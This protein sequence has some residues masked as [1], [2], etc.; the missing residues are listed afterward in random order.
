[1][2]NHDPPPTEGPNKQQPTSH[3]YD[4]KWNYPVVAVSWYDAVTY[5]NWLSKV[6]GFEP[7][8]NTTTWNYD[9]SKNGFHLP[10]EAQWEKAARGNLEQMDF[11]WGN[12]PPD[13]G[14]CNYL[15]YNGSLI[16]IMANLDGNGKGTLPVDTLT[17]NGY[18]LFNM[19]G[20]VWEWCNDWYQDDYYSQSPSP[21]KNP[22]G[23][24]VG[25]KKVIRGGAWNSS[26]IYL[27]CYYR[28][29]KV[30]HT[31]LYDIGF[32]IAR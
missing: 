2:T 27:R 17:A 20:N 23:P 31:K 12:D 30:P 29:S 26:D 10:T 6:A 25:D 16:S 24:T 8:Y 3:Y 11:P 1:M 22:I 14:R 18:V 9:S 15:D 7:C 13:G 21:S 5:C 32:R 28:Y 4:N 19:A